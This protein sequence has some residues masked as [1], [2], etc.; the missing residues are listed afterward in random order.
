MI[1]NFGKDGEII[2]DQLGVNPLYW[3]LVDGSCLVADNANELF[4]SGGVERKVRIELLGEYF[5][6]GWIC[7]PDTIWEGVYKI[8]A[9]CKLIVSAGQVKVE[10]WWH[11]NGMGVSV[12]GSSLRSLVCESI[13]QCVGDGKGVCNWFSGGIDSSLIAAFV[14]DKG[15]KHL[16]MTL[17]DGESDRVRKMEAAFGLDVE[18]LHPD[19]S[20]VIHY[21]ELCRKMGE[22]IADPGIIAAYW[23]GRES[24]KRGCSVVLSGMGGDEV[25]AGYPRNKIVVK[26][27]YCS[28]VRSLGVWVLKAIGWI[29]LVGAWIARGK[30]RR[31]V[32]RLGHFLTHPDVA[33]YFNLFGYF[34]K[35]EIDSLVGPQWFG[36]YRAKV[37]GLTRE[38]EGVRKF[39]G[40]EFKGFLASHNNIY[41][42]QACRAAGVE[43]RTPLL[44]PQLV[45]SLWAD[46]DSPCNAG[47]K[48]LTKILADEIGPAFMKVG[49]SGFRFPIEKN[50]VE[51]DWHEVRVCLERVLRL[52]GLHVMDDCLAALRAGRCEEVYMKLWAFWTLAENIK[53]V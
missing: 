36:A 43:C 40:Y 39:F 38:Y 33:H 15:V 30:R 4:E 17:G 37:E 10:R 26:L 12:G 29:M 21:P 34:T 31:D 25:D 22:P 50:L 28:I 7:E 16:H 13:N 14:R 53:Q 42:A 48:R 6:Q 23:L 20:L 18:R 8:P 51:I 27:F 52:D 47:K 46:I 2:R 24:L 3:S 35:E 44:S 45:Q 41:G 19:P 32:K 1:R 9:G 49:K 11:L 5:A